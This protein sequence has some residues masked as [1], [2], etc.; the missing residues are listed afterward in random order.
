M[1]QIGGL[2]NMKQQCGWQS[3]SNWWFRKYDREKWITKYDRDYKLPENY[4][5]D[6]RNMFNCEFSYIFIQLLVK[7]RIYEF[8][9]M[10]SRRNV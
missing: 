4:N 7:M 10:S 9:E 5:S 2:K 1:W 8:S 6:V 3:V